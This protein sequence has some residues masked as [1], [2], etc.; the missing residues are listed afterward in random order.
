LGFYLEQQLWATKQKDRNPS[1]AG[2]L[3]YACAGETCFVGGGETSRTISV[4]N[5]SGVAIE[6]LWLLT[7]VKT[8]FDQFWTVSTRWNGQ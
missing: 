8:D 7:P 6:T 3:R 2:M 5:R 4:E 1:G